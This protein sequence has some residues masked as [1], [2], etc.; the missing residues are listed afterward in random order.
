MTKPII[1]S[2]NFMPRAVIDLACCL[3]QFSIKLIWKYRFWPAVVFIQ[4]SCVRPVFVLGSVTCLL[5]WEG[6]R[7]GR[8]EL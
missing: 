6:E 4:A 8:Q 2:F 7:E 5:A 1:M 3:C